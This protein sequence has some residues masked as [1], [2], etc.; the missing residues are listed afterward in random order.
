MAFLRQGREGLYGGG[1]LC[2]MDVLNRSQMDEEMDK[3]GKEEDLA[4]QSPSS[5]PSP[6]ERL[7]SI[8]PLSPSGRVTQ[9]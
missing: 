6:S 4:C 9:Y 5:K 3:G 8:L 7:L 1:N 2:R